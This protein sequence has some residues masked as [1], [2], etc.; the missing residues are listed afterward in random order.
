M[1]EDTIADKVIANKVVPLTTRT[2]DQESLSHCDPLQ[3]KTY[4]GT[5]TL[6]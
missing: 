1:D 4:L 6:L 3:R 2:V 5:D